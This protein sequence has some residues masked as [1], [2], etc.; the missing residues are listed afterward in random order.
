M[1][2]PAVAWLQIFVAWASSLVTVVAMRLGASIASDLAQLDLCPVA[3]DEA[4][5]DNFDDWIPFLTD[6][7]DWSPFWPLHP[8]QE[9]AS[10]ESFCGSSNNMNLSEE[11][12]KS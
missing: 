2:G 9:C 4:Q 3:S 6:G 1:V 10:F 5:L 11:Q 8:A 7:D 12:T